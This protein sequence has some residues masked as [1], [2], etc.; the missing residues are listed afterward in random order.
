MVLLQ[1]A[2]PQCSRHEGPRSAE[3]RRRNI[4]ARG[5]RG[6]S[7]PDSSRPV[8]TT[9]TGTQAT[10]EARRGPVGAGTASPP[11]TAALPRPASPDA[12]AQRGPSAGPGTGHGRV[13]GAP[14]PARSRPAAQPRPAGTKGAEPQPGP[15]HPA[16]QSTMTVLALSPQG[17][18]S[19]VRVSST[20]RTTGSSTTTAQQPPRAPRREQEAPPATARSRPRPRA[21]IEPA[22]TPRA[23]R[24]DRSRPGRRS[25]RRQARVP[26]RRACVRPARPL[27]RPVTSHDVLSRSAG[28]RDHQTT[29]SGAGPVRD[30]SSLPGH[31][32]APLRAVSVKVGRVQHLQDACQTSASGPERP[33]VSRPRPPT[34]P[35]GRPCGCARLHALSPEGIDRAWCSPETATRPARRRPLPGRGG[36]GRSVPAAGELGCPPALVLGHAASVGRVAA[37]RQ[38]VTTRVRVNGC[39]TNLPLRAA[40]A[41]PSVVRPRTRGRRWRPEGDDRRR[42]R[43]CPLVQTWIGRGARRGPAWDGVTPEHPT[44]WSTAVTT[45]AQAPAKGRG[46]A[47]RSLHQGAASPAAPATLRRLRRTSSCSANS[48]CRPVGPSWCASTP[49]RSHPRPCGNGAHGRRWSPRTAGRR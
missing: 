48:A 13:D 15:A 49:P 38:S 16:S 24:G 30:A 23:R 10:P 4:G 8:G 46:D 27:E 22:G 11:S 14:G 33:H 7:G 39:R 42:G 44:P 20:S 5:R 3:R 28:R 41:A 25:E 29:Q 1:Q 35:P 2:P 18:S 40:D 12:P 17:S 9:T 34:A 19:R 31:R 37:G 26:A 36:S 21:R 43:A 45:P 6:S 32:L 47:A